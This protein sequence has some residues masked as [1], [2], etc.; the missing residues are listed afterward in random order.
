MLNH[1]ESALQIRIDHR[2]KVGLLHGEQQAVARDAGVVHQNVDLPKVRQNLC[3]RI[4]CRIKVGHVAAV[5][6]GGH[7]VLC[8]KRAC[9]VGGLF[10]ARIHDRNIGAALCHLQCN[11]T[12]DTA[13]TSGDNRSLIG[14]QKNSSFSLSS[15]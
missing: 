2:V 7:A 4:L 12:A 10:V 3:H 9:L 8:G 6:F 14:Q 11:R 13:G 5:R 15:F 1:M